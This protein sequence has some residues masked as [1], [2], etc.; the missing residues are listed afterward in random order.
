MTI[1]RAIQSDLRHVLQTVPGLPAV[2]HWQGRPFTR[3]HGVTYV[4][5]RL[6]PVDANVASLGAHGNTRELWNYLIDLFTPSGDGI[7]TSYDLSDAVRRTFHA[8]RTIGSAAIFG[9]VT[10]A[11]ISPILTGSD[12]HQ[13]PVTITGFTYRETVA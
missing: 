11:R 13:L 9:R 12:W 7:F 10:D 4:Q 5:E 8:G 3:E 2:V 1:Y 6:Q